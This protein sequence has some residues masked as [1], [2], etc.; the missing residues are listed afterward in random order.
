MNLFNGKFLPKLFVATPFFFAGYFSVVAVWAFIKLPEKTGFPDGV[1]SYTTIHGINPLNDYLRIAVLFIISLIA[2]AVGFKTGE[3]IVKKLTR[4]QPPAGSIDPGTASPEV[5][6]G[7]FLDGLSPVARFLISS[8]IL[9]IAIP[10]LGRYGLY[11]TLTDGFHEG[12][13][14]GYLP[15]WKATGAIFTE[16]FIIHGFGRNILPAIFADFLSGDGESIIYYTRFYNFI[17]SMI[18]LVL[19]WLI[20][21]QSYDLFRGGKKSRFSDVLVMMSSFLAIKFLFYMNVP[22]TG[23]DMILFFQMFISLF[24]L[25]SA[26]APEKVRV[27]ISAAVL[28]ATLPLGF[29]NAY[30][31]GII[32]IVVTGVTLL[33]FLYTV[34]KGFITTLAAGVAGVVISGAVVYLA[35]GKNELTAM[36]E[37]VNYWSKYA[38][39]TWDV[40]LTGRS[41]ISITLFGIQNIFVIVLAVYLLLTRF[42]G[43]ET[44]VEFVKRYP[45]LILALAVSLVFLRMAAGRSDTNHLFDATVPVI[46]VTTFLLAVFFESDSFSGLFTSRKTGNRFVTG[47]WITALLLALVVNKPVDTLS[48]YARVINGGAE[49]DRAL[50]D[51]YYVDATDSI[52]KEMKG[53]KYF[54]TLTSEG[55]W[56]Q[57]L[58]VRP[59]VRFHQLLYARTTAYQ[60]EVIDSLEKLKPSIILFSNDQF[61]GVMD[62]VSVFNSNG[63]IMSYV[64]ARYRPFLFIE[65]QWFWKRDTSAYRFEEGEGDDNSTAKFK[66]TASRLNDVTVTGKYSSKNAGNSGALLLRNGKTGEFIS[67]ARPGGDTS[68]WSITVPTAVLHDGVNRLEVWKWSDEGGALQSLSG[69]IEVTITR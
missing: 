9:I 35:F 38:D 3:L 4:N 58:N 10:L 41:F 25:K 13:M 40:E 39:L 51:K 59:P 57:L 22:V 7:N 32:G 20:I 60:N 64:I 11:H 1:I 55:V 12:E 26:F 52:K 6:P 16:A 36:L 27:L 30:D 19:M 69:M 62:S 65:G 37:Q 34:R 18:A 54:Y 56:Y 63:I 23:R 42:R 33:I 53:E 61:P 45:G 8:A 24:L 43:S 17:T 67:A 5:Q 14:F 15:A 68:S 50:A 46:M 66:I 44:R 2:L 28:G 49:T 21:K 47:V 31:R 48:Q 29:L